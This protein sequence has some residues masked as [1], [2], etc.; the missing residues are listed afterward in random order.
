MIRSPVRYISP[1]TRTSVLAH[2]IVFFSPRCCPPCA[3]SACLMSSFAISQMSVII[4][5]LGGLFV[6]ILALPYGPCRS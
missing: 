6:K 1:C 2:F 4:P 3:A 5:K